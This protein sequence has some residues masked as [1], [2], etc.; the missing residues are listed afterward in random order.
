MNTKASRH[1][2]LTPSL[3]FQAWNVSVA[4]AVANVAQANFPAYLDAALSSLLPI[5]C[6]LLGLEC[7][8]QPP[9]PIYQ[10]GIPEIYL[11]NLTSRYYARGY[12]LDPFCLAIENGLAQGFYPLAEIAPD[13]FFS[14]EYYKN[15]YLKCGA[16]EDSHYIIDLDDQRKL[17]LC[18]YQGC[19]GS[20]FSKSQLNLLRS[21]E[22]LVR[23]LCLQFDRTGGLAQCLPDEHAPSNLS[24]H[25]RA[26]FMSF[27]GDG[28]TDREREIAHLL[29]RGHSVKSSAKVLEISPQTVRMHRK[30][31]YTKL[32]V[33]SQAELFALFIDWLTRY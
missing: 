29:L 4:Q 26:A 28:L 15:Y 18:V 12:L 14:S 10:R 8:G 33:N 17:S 31:L 23:E 30:N 24:R 2:S 25:I 9:Q 20:R 27:G 1:P 22:P 21:A 13:N 32:A 3:G 7:K 5:E 19:S 11:E 6:V 16:V